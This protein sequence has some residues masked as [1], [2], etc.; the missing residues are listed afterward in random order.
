MWGRIGFSQIGA[1]REISDGLHFSIARPACQACR[2]VSIEGVKGYG[3]RGPLFNRN[4]RAS[5]EP[6]TVASSTV[7]VFVLSPGRSRSHQLWKD[8]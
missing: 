8:L 7:D 6:T 3:A 5:K 1:F 2:V 4:W